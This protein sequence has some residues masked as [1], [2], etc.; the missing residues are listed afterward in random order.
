MMND[1]LPWIIFNVV[2]L[3]LLAVD[4]FFHRQARNV[5]M[6]EA[7]LWSLFWIS[8]ALLFNVYIYYARGSQDGIDFLT[9][10]LIEKALSVDN[11]FVFLLIFKYFHTPKSYLHKVLFWGV[12]G[13][14]VMRALFIWLGIALITNFHWILYLFGAFL[15][16]TG[17]K[18]GLEKDKEI[19]PEHNFVLRI[20]KYFFPVTKHYSDDK[21]LVLENGKYFA[22]PLLVVLVAI[23]TTDLIFAVD[24]IPAIL[25]IT[26]DPF[27]VYTSNICAILGLRS[28]FFVLS[29]IMSLFHYLHY[30]L[31]FILTFIGA[32]M[33]FADL[34]K[35]PTGITLGIVFMIL[36]LSIIASICFPKKNK[37]R[38]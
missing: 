1:L 22:T 19:H 4:L 11:L 30:A 2:V 7:S 6:K 10:Y 27:I 21:F 31:S 35:I 26:T 17:I 12:L 36:L 8:L 28:L 14:I 38:Q 23:E 20:F 33:L 29:H 9:G 5:S 18:L 37:G 25:A 34:I 3:A 15:I 32:K 24:S 13:A 16:Y